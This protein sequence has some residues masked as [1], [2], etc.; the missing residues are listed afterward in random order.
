[1][2]Y[3]YMDTCIVKN[4]KQK[5]QF[6]FVLCN[7]AK[8]S[9][10]HPNI[11]ICVCFTG[12][13]HGMTCS[14][15]LLF[16][17][18]SS[19]WCSDRWLRQEGSPIPVA[20]QYPTVFVL[21]AMKSGSSSMYSLLTKHP[22][23]CGGQK[24]EPGYFKRSGGGEFSWDEGKFAYRRNYEFNRHCDPRNTQGCMDVKKCIG[25]NDTRFVDGTAMLHTMSTI[26]ER[27]EKSYIAA[28]RE[29]LRFIVLLR[30]PVSRDYSLFSHACRRILDRG[31]SFAKLK[32][33]DERL[34]KESK[35]HF[36]GNYLDE[37]KEF[38][39]LFRR[40]QIFVVNSDAVFK[41]SPE[42][43]RDIA[44]FLDLPFISDWNIPFPQDD[45]QSAIEIDY[46]DCTP[47]HVPELDCQ[48]RDYLI[49]HYAAKN[50]N[51]TD[52]MYLHGPRPRSE[53]AFI[54]FSDKVKSMKC[55][56]NARKAYNKLISDCLHDRKNPQKCSCGGTF[57]HIN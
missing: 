52:Y 18:F 30:E 28:D 4:E 48:L 51:L 25:H 7:C 16:S 10:T 35:G 44:Q 57:L 15:L 2:V 37:L 8:Q 3:G 49:E 21:G 41:D 27:M 38:E 6:V 56:T 31:F 17:L 40:D 47:Q 5:N 53:P 24:K 36:F 26:V 22:K 46:P 34:A 39:K 1:M 11:N 19:V 14:V 20:S 32:T 33:F 45:H 9:A 29:Q 43:M 23:L 42:V 13:L 50:A 54:P 55:N 12:M